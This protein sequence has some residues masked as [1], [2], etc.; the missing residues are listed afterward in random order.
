MNYTHPA[1]MYIGI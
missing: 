1:D